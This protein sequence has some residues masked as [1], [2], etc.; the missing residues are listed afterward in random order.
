[1]TWVVV[2][3][4]PFVVIL[5]LLTLREPLKVGL[6]V[7]TALIP[8]GG[9]LSVGSSPF[10]S[11]SSLMGV[12]LGVGLVGQLVAGR[13]SAPRLSVTVPIWVLFLGLAAATTLWTIDREATITGFVVLSSLVV[14]FLL[15]SVSHADRTV[16]RRTESALLL[17]SSGAVLQGL[18]QVLAGGGLPAEDGAV[19]GDGR[20]GEALLGP[21][22]L[23][24]TLLVPL[25]I[26]VNRALNPRES[27]RRAPYLALAAL[28]LAGI[29][30]TGSRT[31][32]VGAGVLA[33]AMA[34]SLPRSARRGLVLSMVAGAALTA[35]VW[36]AHPFGLAERS[37]E[38]AT[39]SSGRLEIWEVGLAACD[40]YC[41]I[42]S[43]WGTFPDVYA[44]TQAGVAGARVLTGD[45]GS[46][47]PHNL[48]LLA[49]IELGVAGFVLVSAGL[50]ATVMQALRLPP[51]YRPAAVGA[52]VG[53]VVGMLFLSSMEFKVFWWVLAL[54]ALYRNVVLA[55]EAERSADSVTEG[56]QT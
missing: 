18:F 21:N 11:A 16:V 52:V 55:E 56:V 31:G 33:L 23:A 47:Q 2:A 48:W 32:L 49:A 14:I 22:I 53:L 29:V 4:A 27:G 17:G 30:M 15:V 43:G 54:V 44:E 37:F 38:T 40:S 51:E 42:G 10:G 39:S 19:E 35:F 20:F 41:V 26:A 1:M 34:W 25:A 7:Y 6:P 28:M 45:Q 36:T 8:F 13:R 5:A 50:V 24:V 46:Y 9:A 3:A 12:L